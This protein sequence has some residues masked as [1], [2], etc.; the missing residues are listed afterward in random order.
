M[1]PLAFRQ[2]GGRAVR[3]SQEGVFH[4]GLGGGALFPRSE[5]E[6]DVRQRDV[7]GAAVAD[8]GLGLS[9]AEEAVGHDAVLLRH[10]GVVPEAGEDVLEFP[11]TLPNLKSL[12]F[13]RTLEEGFQLPGG[14]LKLFLRK[15]AKCPVLLQLPPDVFPEMFR[16]LAGEAVGKMERTAGGNEEVQHGAA[17]GVLLAQFPA[18]RNPGV[19]SA[20]AG[21]VRLLEAPVADAWLPVVIQHDGGSGRI[22]KPVSEV[23][24]ERR[25]A[26]KMPLVRREAGGLAVGSAEGFRAALVNEVDKLLEGE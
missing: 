18:G 14:L 2:G 20:H 26:D 19:V 16:T 7:I 12:G 11:V 23:A 15:K 9:R 4:Q 10:H 5:G 25:R 1:Q 21:V 3:G 17:R 8:G 13:F 6:G 22:T 24:H